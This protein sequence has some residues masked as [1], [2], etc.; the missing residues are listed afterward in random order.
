MPQLELPTEIPNWLPMLVVWM[1]LCVLAWWALL[2]ILEDR[3]WH[4]PPD[5]RAG[6]AVTVAA[7]LAV[8]GGIVLLVWRGGV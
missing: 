5:E 1:A 3:M 7:V 8:L 4:R 2:A 6:W